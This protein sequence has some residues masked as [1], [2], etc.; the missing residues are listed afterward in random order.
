V[1]FQYFSFSN[2][3]FPSLV[4]HSPFRYSLTQFWSVLLYMCTY[5]PLYM[6]IYYTYIYL[7]YVSNIHMRESTDFGSFELCLLCLTWRF[8]VPSIQLQTT[9]LLSSLWLNKSPLCLY[10]TSPTNG[11]G[12]TEFLPAENENNIP[13]S[14]SALASI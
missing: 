13:V 1:F 5:I 6:L 3:F 14:N 12:K 8:P 11:A 2:I 9:W 10:T 4:S 7:T